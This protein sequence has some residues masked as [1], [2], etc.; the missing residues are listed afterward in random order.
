MELEEELALARGLSVSEL[1]EA[2][3]S[4]GFQCTRC[5]ACCKGHGETHT[6]TVF[7]E[8]IR[9]IA[10]EEYDWR[11]VV[12]PMPFGLGDH[13]GETFEW[14]LAADE[15]GD[16]SFYDEST[17]EGVCTVY[18]DRPSICQTYP[19]SI[20]VAG[21]TPMGDVVDEEGVVMAHECEGLGLEIEREEALELAVKLRE[22]AITE[23]EEMIAVR[24]K[25]EPIP[26][27]DGEIVVHDSEGMK[28]PDGTRIER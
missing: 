5:G 13:G 3:M 1:A 24:E 16:C 19:F 10:G 21:A 20:D 7:P 6:A 14:S 22:R 9:Q 23:L 8:E 28:R 12:R 26:T 18:E 2:I 25:Y 4:I 11:D 15:C 27:E 17:E